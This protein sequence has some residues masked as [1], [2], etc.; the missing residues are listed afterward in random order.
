MI[1]SPNKSIHRI[2]YCQPVIS[3]NGEKLIETFP[4]EITLPTVRLNKLENNQIA[5]D[6]SNYTTN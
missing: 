1:G 2:G 3:V 4:D 5:I 6:G